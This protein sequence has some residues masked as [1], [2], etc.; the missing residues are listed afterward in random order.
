MIRHFVR[1]ALVA[2]ALLGSVVVSD[3]APVE[4]AQALPGCFVCPGPGLEG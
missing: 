4:S 3:P 2:A 1:T